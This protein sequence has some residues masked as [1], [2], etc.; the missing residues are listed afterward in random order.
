MIYV[1]D[2]DGTLAEC[3]YGNQRPCF[4]N[5]RED[6]V[7]RSMQRN[8]Y[9]YTKPLPHV[10]KFLDN[11]FETETLLGDKARFAAITH[12]MNGTEFTQKQDF[13]SGLFRTPDQE[14]YFDK[15]NIYGVTQAA[16][17]Y[18]VLHCLVSRYYEPTVYFDDN[19]DI[20]CDINNKQADN[21]LCSGKAM[22]APYIMTVH[23]S[24]MCTRTASEIRMAYTR[25]ENDF[26]YLKNSF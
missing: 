3:W 25:S 21:A 23:S 10:Q 16:D 24:S 5:T 2:I 26:K 20:L 8:L 18:H 19:I 12:I 4:Y 6:I 9:E 7:T 11:I 1:F 13:L 15:D 22:Q 14:P 17:K